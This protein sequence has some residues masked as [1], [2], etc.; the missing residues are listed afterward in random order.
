MRAELAPALIEELEKFT[1][2]I[3]WRLDCLPFGVAIVY[4]SGNHFTIGD[5]INEFT[6]R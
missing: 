6:R 3:W 1:S 2:P 4:A 5:K